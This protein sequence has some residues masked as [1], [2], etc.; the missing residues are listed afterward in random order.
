M[1]CWTRPV[2][3]QDFRQVIKQDKDVGESDA[4]PGEIALRVKSPETDDDGSDGEICRD[5]YPGKE[6]VA[7]GQV[8]VQVLGSVQRRIVLSR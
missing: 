5:S 6:A 4:Q 8:A 1:S 3:G 2:D 7:D